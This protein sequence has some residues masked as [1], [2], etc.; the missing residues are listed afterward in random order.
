MTSQV[1]KWQQNVVLS[2]IA[3]GQD[4]GMTAMTTDLARL[5]QHVNHVNLI[6]FSV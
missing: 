1:L 3:N 4:F 2:D 5:I 6:E